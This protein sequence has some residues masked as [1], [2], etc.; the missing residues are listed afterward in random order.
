MCRSN[1]FK[2]CISTQLEQKSLNVKL[3]RRDSW[4]LNWP[5][6]LCQANKTPPC[7][8]C[9]FSGWLADF[10]TLS[11]SSCQCW[12]LSLVTVTVQLIN[13]WHSSHHT[14]LSVQ[15]ICDKRKYSQQQHFVYCFRS[16]FSWHTQ[17]LNFSGINC[18]WFSV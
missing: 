6:S 3:K 18:L 16:L 9:I 2:N 5:C 17:K 15:S 7:Q 10:M 4:Q 13:N 12:T 14:V 11:H 8:T 1:S